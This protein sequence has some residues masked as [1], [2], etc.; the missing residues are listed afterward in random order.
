MVQT[1]LV[2][3]YL[4][5]T[6]LLASAAALAWVTR[7]LGLSYVIGYIVAGMALSYLLPALRGDVEPLLEVFSDIAIALLSFEIG[8]EVGL[9]N[10]R[11]IGPAAIII[12]LSEV[13][14][15][16][17]ITVIVSLAFKLSWSEVVVLTFMT[18]S[19]STAVTAKL[20]EERNIDEHAKRLVFSVAM[21]DDVVAIIALTLLPQISH[22]HVEFFDALKLTAL[23]LVTAAILILVGVTLVR[24]IFAKIVK[25]DEFGM[26]VSISLGFAYA[27][28]SREAGLSP[29]LG[30]FAAGLA[31]SAHPESS[32]IGLHMRPMREIFLVL[33]FVTMGLNTN[34][35]MVSTQHVALI[36]LLTLLLIPA[37]MLALSS[38]FWIFGGLSLEKALEAGFSIITVSEFG[39]VIAYEASRLGISSLPLLV[40]ASTVMIV[41]VFSASLLTRRLEEYTV[42]FSSM[43]PNQVKL[44]GDRLSGYVNRALEGGVGKMIR[45]LFMKIVK[46]A[47]IVVLAAFLSSFMLY[48]VDVSLVYPH[49][50]IASLLIISIAMVVIILAAKRLYVHADGLCIAFL[51]KERINPAMK[52]VLRSLIF[53][54]LITLTALTALLTASQ[55]IAS[56][57]DRMV[58][59]EIGRSVAITIILVLIVI[60]MMAILSK[61][62]RMALIREGEA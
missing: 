46:E 28:I 31:L 48:V 40:I 34:I 62:K 14:A 54:G 49:N 22:G 29:A 10:I 43:I 23:S 58:G 12:V 57:I 21:T 17:T 41:S 36:V 5:L 16:F 1:K 52:G 51:C 2:D 6:V 53:L 30:A 38:S 11:R 56:L 19:C 33:F 27:L 7:R 20:L 25:A 37:R 9:S 8:R 15:A 39:L 26:A 42:K 45:D 24:K 4:L 55:Y 35:M 3:I 44:F 13:L 61:L 47:A 50:I 60:A 32:K 18:T 59:F